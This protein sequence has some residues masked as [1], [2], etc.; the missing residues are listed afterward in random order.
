MNSMASSLSVPD[1]KRLLHDCYIS[2]TS[3]MSVLPLLCAGGLY[4]HSYQDWD[5]GRF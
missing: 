3:V 2:A 1:F 4:Q 5:N